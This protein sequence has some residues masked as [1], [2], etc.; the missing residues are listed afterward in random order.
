MG[1]TTPKS[2]NPL[3]LT[4]QKPTGYMAVN[5]KWLYPLLFWNTLQTHYKALK[6]SDNLL[7]SIS[8]GEGMPLS[9]K[10]LDWLLEMGLKGDVVP[11][12]EPDGCTGRGEPVVPSDRVLSPAECEANLAPVSGGMGEPTLIGLSDLPGNDIRKGQFARV[13][14]SVN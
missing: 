3:Y 2:L 4:R 7:G 6:S 5:S 11:E 8:R 12:D 13:Q 9:S 14:K 10:S 1:A